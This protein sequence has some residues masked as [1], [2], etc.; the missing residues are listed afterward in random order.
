MSCSMNSALKVL[1]ISL[2]GAQTILCIVKTM[3]GERIF[4]FIRLLSNKCPS[5]KLG[6]GGGALFHHKGFAHP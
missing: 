2:M 3:A 5:V 1:E 6:G 4:I